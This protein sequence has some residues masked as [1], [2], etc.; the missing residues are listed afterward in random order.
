MDTVDAN[1][2]AAPASDDSDDEA[3]LTDA[4][5]LQMLLLRVRN[6]AFAAMV[7][8][9]SEDA[10]LRAV[11]TAAEKYRHIVG[12]EPGGEPKPVRHLAAVPA[13]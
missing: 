11:R 10:C 7:N 4:M 1:P 2:D 9:A 6:V 5:R 13:G 12:E 8:D 3:L